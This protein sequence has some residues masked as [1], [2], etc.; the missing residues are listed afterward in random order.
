MQPINYGA[1]LP[2]LDFTGL[3]RGLAIRDDRRQAQQVTDARMAQIQL[4]T[5]KAAR[6]AADKARYQD[7][8]KEVLENPSTEAY[9]RMFLEF[10]DQLDGLKAGLE[11]YTGAQKSR[12]MN[13]AMEVLGLVNAGAVPAAVAR[14]KAR[15]TALAEAG[16]TTEIT[17]TIIADLESGDEKRIAR[18]KGTAAFALYPMLGDDADKVLNTLGLGAKAETDDRRLDIAER[19]AETAEEQGER[20]LGLSER[21]ADRADAAAARAER[22]ASAKGGGSGDDGYEYRIGPNGKLQRRK[23]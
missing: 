9:Q 17:D 21:A 12:N 22:K 18:A 14:L 3:Q 4:A 2:Q 19:R 7:R 20:R 16:E 5:D 1:M 23:R 13:A 6:E 8:V 10:P 15:R 11:S